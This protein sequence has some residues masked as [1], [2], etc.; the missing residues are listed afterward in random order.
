MGVGATDMRNPVSAQRRIPKNI[1]AERGN[2]QPVAVSLEGKRF[3]R[4][5][6]E[7]SASFVRSPV[8]EIGAEIDRW[9]REIVLGLNLDRGALAQIDA[10]SG[11][12]TVRHSWGRDH[13]VKLPIGLELARPAPWFDGTLMKGRTV[14]FSRVKELPP[15]FLANDW[16][17]F[18]RYVPKSNIT[19]P[20]RVAGVVVGALGFASLKRERTWPPRLI[21]RLELVAEIF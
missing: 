16:I 20:I 1:H 2:R 6:E 18:R 19:L 4:F 9:I 11:K 17:T 10:R 15:E 14:A 3:E 21:R 7:L 13:L 8:D 12:L 5:I